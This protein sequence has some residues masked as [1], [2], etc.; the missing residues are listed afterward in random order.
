[1]QNVYLWEYL[2]FEK[3]VSKLSVFAECVP[4]DTGLIV[5]LGSVHI[6][7]SW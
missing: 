5:L 7:T 4:G 6:H 2:P 3:L 1:M